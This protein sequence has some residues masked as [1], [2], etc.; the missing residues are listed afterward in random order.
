MYGFQ[1]ASRL[2][3]GNVPDAERG[4]RGGSAALRGSPIRPVLL[5]TLSINQGEV[6]TFSSTKYTINRGDIRFLNPIKIEPTIDMD[7]ETEN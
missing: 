4:V 3:G 7:L 6:Q 2:P 5:G 1:I